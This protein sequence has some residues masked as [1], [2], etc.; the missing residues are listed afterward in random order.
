MKKEITFVAGLLL[1]LS[2]VSFASAG[3]SSKP[4]QIIMQLSASSNAHGALWNQSYT[5][6]ICYNDIFKPDYSG[7]GPH[8]CT[9]SDV[10][11]YLYDNNNSHA[12]WPGSSAYTIKVC[13]KG[14]TDCGIGSCLQRDKDVTKCREIAYI[15]GTGAII[16]N[17]HLWP[18]TY[19]GLDY[20]PISCDCVGDCERNDKIYLRCGDFDGD[21]DGCKDPDANEIAK[22]DP[23]CGATEKNLC[24]CSWNNTAHVCTLSETI[25]IIDPLSGD[26]CSYNNVKTGTDA[27]ECSGGSKIVEYTCTQT[28]LTPGCPSG[29]GCESI[30][31][32]VSC[33]GTEASLP[34]FGSWQI[35][36]SLISITLVYALLGRKRLL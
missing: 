22:I 13:H 5:P 17:S 35:I 33:G 18:R 24:H 2:L 3:C 14:L 7:T 20:L 9:T 23:G 10:L 16:N 30:S 25:F 6:N 8:E 15:S 1:F 27:T 26:E 19:V 4:D 31:A 29:P 32:T 21:V 28:S 12:A 34:F 11:L 36:S